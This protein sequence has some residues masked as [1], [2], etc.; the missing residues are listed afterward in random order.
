MKRNE[1]PHMAASVISFK[2]LTVL[3]S[4]CVK[5]RLWIKAMYYTNLDV[6][7]VQLL[8]IILITQLTVKQEHIR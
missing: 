1:P 7:T 8:V 5:H 3:I 4:D 6:N 2:K